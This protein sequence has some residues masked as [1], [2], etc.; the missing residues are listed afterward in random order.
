[1]FNCFSDRSSSSWSTSLS[2]ENIQ[3]RGLRGVLTL[4]CV[5]TQAH[6]CVTGRDR[7]LGAWNVAGIHEVFTEMN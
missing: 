1:M 5:P 7:V 2:H 4:L 6:P 3:R